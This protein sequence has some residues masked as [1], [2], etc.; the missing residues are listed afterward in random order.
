M[1]SSERNELLSQPFHSILFTF[2]KYLNCRN[3]VFLGACE[4]IFKFIYKFL[5]GHYI[6]IQFVRMKLPRDMA[7]L[8]E[9]SRTLDLYE[10]N[11]YNLPINFITFSQLTLT[12][13][14]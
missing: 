7:C 14:P 12:Y 10:T 2:P 8:S 1:K 9:K 13:I 4:Q 11:H 5:R 3:V 6:K